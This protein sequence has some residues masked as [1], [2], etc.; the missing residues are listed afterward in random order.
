MK[1]WKVQDSGKGAG[2]GGT[3]SYAI[4]AGLDSIDAEQIMYGYSPGKVYTATAILRHGHFLQWGYGCGPAKMTESGRQLFVNCIVHI[5]KFNG[6]RPFV[7]NQCY[8]PDTLISYIGYRVTSNRSLDVYCPQEIIDKFSSSELIREYKN[9]KNFIYMK[10]NRYYIDYELK[11]L[12]IGSNADISN[13]DKF[14]SMLNDSNKAAVGKT[15]LL[16]YTGK[17]FGR[18]KDAKEWLDTNR[19]YLL[20]IPRCNYK[21][22]VLPDKVENIL[23]HQ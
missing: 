2:S 1:V 12:G 23:K 20:F 16:R 14:S 3:V 5:S 19:E 21:F 8:S 15:M 4:E 9:N 11:K 10:D 7:T 18:Y 22:M 13:L 6:K 17:E